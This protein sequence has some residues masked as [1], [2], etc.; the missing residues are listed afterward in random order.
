MMR[1]SSGR[2]KDP[3]RFQHPA[4]HH[5]SIVIKT[6]FPLFIVVANVETAFYNLCLSQVADATPPPSFHLLFPLKYCLAPFFLPL[7]S[8][9]L[10]ACVCARMTTIVVSVNKT[11]A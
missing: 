1:G 10:F 11:A 5:L 9:S 3:T 2:E 8:I 7:L 4:L 6:P